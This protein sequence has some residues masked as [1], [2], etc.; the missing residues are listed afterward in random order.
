MHADTL[1]NLQREWP[2][3][4]LWRTESLWLATRRGPRPE[5]PDGFFSTNG[6]LTITLMEDDLSGLAAALE[7]QALIE[8]ELSTFLSE[9]RV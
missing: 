7:A 5:V 6:Y 8:G 4:K 1:E 9:G 3:W 2:H